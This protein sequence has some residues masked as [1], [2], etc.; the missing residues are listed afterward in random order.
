[1]NGRSGPVIVICG[2]PG[3]GKS[4]LAHRLERI[5]DVRHRAGTQTILHTLRAIKPKDPRNKPLSALDPGI[6]A[7]ELRKKMLRQAQ[8]MSKA[9]NYILERNANQGIPF[10]LEGL[11]ILP[12]IINM[13][14][15]SLCVVL[16]SPPRRS[17]RRWLQHRYI[18]RPTVF[19]MEKA[20]T[21]NR[22]ILDDAKRTKGVHIIT[23]Y[24]TAE[25][26]QRVLHFL[27]KKGFHSPHQYLRRVGYKNL[28][29]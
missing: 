14:P 15:V 1:M 28:S 10:I 29:A 13:K 23:E 20:Y 11:H 8:Y 12:S 4:T 21:M 7:T 18:A 27:H 2:A 5:L 25:R 26:V 19:S 24:K 16:A 6:P 9:I 17:Y 22:I 3:T